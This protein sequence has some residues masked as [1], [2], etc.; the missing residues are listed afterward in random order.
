MFE[1]IIRLFNETALKFGLS[2][3]YSALAS[4][5]A[6]FIGLVIVAFFLYYVS[7]FVIKKTLIVFIRRS[8]NNFDDIL[9]EN[10]VLSR[11]SYFVP[12]YIISKFAPYTLP[13]F[14]VAFEFVQKSIEVYVVFVWMIL[15]T[16]LVSS[17]YQFYNTLDVSKNKPIK[18]FT[19]VIKL[20]VYIVG[21]LMIIA[22]IVG[23]NLG[24]LVIGLGTLSAVL[25]LIFKDPILGFVGG[26][27]LS[28]NDMVRIGDWISMPKYGA[29]GDVLEITLTTV[30]VQN[31][32]R[33]ITT[34]PTYALVSDSFTNWRG[35]EESGGRRVKRFVNL[36]MESVKFCD[37]EMLARF[38]KF[39]LIK[40]YIIQKEEE[41][42]A[43]NKANNIETESLVNGR[44][45]TNLGVFRAYL[46]AYL[47]AHPKVHKEMT[48]LVRHLQPSEKGIPIEVYFFS[49]RQAWAEYEDL[50][51]DVFDHVLAVIP[52][53]DL[54]VFQIPSGNSIEKAIKTLNEK[55]Q[56]S[57]KL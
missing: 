45:Q 51:S 11:A 31:W 53:F 35:M 40:D 23:Q 32:D 1:D 48:M 12:S 4:E 41:V 25:M 36:D 33:T 39:Q 47:M 21:G 37:S 3:R 7:W 26:L 6:A 15:L 55:A 43:Y 18:G 56:V 10:K 50:Q 30:K 44:R 14:P 38:Q 27:Q 29:D 8:E 57:I 52:L 22:T 42:A 24:S 34:I 2:E 20:V 19:Q 46:K 5:G 54:K 13:S 16:A 28:L 17:L 49:N 9:V